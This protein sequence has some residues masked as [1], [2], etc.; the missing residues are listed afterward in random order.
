MHRMPSEQHRFIKQTKNSQ[1]KC[2]RFREQS[3]GIQTSIDTRKHRPASSWK[4]R[5]AR[6]TF[7]R[8]SNENIEFCLFGKINKNDGSCD[9]ANLHHPSR[10]MRGAVKYMPSNWLTAFNTRI[11][12]NFFDLKHC[13]YDYRIRSLVWCAALNWCFSSFPLISIHSLRGACGVRE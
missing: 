7:K 9:V 4:Q 3:P 5:N 6:S 11:R 8:G 13:P 10:C 1:Q 2:F 12:C